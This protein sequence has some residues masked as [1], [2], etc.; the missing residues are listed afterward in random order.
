MRY[1]YLNFFIAYFLA[2]QDS[3]C[4]S[5]F[6]QLI[7]GPSLAVGAISHDNTSCSAK[8]HITTRVTMT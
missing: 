6:A 5:I 3:I 4:T 2:T 8:T 1:M 7:I